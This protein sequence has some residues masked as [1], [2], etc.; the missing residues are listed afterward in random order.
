LPNGLL[1]AAGGV[2]KNRTAVELGP[3]AV[4]AYR[5]PNVKLPGLDGPVTLYAVPTKQ[6]VVTIACVPGAKT[7][8]GVANT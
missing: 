1:R 7:C 6:G 3:K 8:D 2:P 5:Y 4:Q